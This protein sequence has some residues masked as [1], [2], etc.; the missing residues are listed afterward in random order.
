MTSDN[1]TEVEAVEPQQRSR[2][3]AAD[4]L[5]IDEVPT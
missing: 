2:W 1:V 4:R 5:V 3:T